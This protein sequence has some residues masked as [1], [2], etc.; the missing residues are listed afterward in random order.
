MFHLRSNQ[1]IFSFFNVSFFI[2]FSYSDYYIDVVTPG[3]EI[4]GF[5]SDNEIF[6]DTNEPHVLVRGE[7]RQ[8]DTNIVPS[9]EPPQIDHLNN[10]ITSSQSSITPPLQQLITSA[11]EPNY[12]HFNHQYNQPYYQPI[13]YQ[14]SQ[15]FQ[16]QY[17]IPM[18]LNNQ[19]SQAFNYQYS[20]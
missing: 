7:E 1:S 5:D 12:Q 2:L 16:N 20:H 19:Y 4:D 9:Y 10:E 8:F 11:I 18:L 17:H 3:E 15:L 14:Y 13:H 6:D